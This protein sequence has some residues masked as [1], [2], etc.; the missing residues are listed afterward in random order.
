M[1][2]FLR[3]KGWYSLQ[4][5]KT[6]ENIMSYIYV[7]EL[8]RYGRLKFAAKFFERFFLLYEPFFREN[9][10]KNKIQQTVPY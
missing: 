1:Y 9:Q 2:V 7:S 5:N 6:G 10:I 3:K 8:S 4:P